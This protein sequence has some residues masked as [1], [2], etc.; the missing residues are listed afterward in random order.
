VRKLTATS[1]SRL[2]YKVSVA[3]NGGEAL[4]LMEKK[5]L[6]TDL[7]ITDV[8]M[9]YMSGKELVNR[10]QINQPD[11]KVL[12]MSGY[13]DDAIF[14]HG[15]LEPGTAFIHKPFTLRGIA[16]KVQAALRG[17]GGAGNQ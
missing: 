1:L 15:V 7:I 17:T 16:E 4:L 10:L 2:G 5:G 9:P 13:T 6:K 3:A 8:V 11:L 14:P 12:Y